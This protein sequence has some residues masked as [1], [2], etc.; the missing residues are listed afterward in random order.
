MEIIKV[1]MALIKSVI[2]KTKLDKPLTLTETDSQRLFDLSKAHDMAHLVAFSIDFNEVKVPSNVKANFQKEQ[3][4]AVF[5][6]E[7]SNYEIQALYNLFEENNIEYVPLKGA[8]L[9]AFYPEPYLRTSADIDILVHEEQIEKSIKL[10]CEK[11][12]YKQKVYGPHDISLI[13]PSGVNF[14]L[15][16]DLLDNEI[17][18]KTPKPLEDMWN[19]TV[20]NDNGSLRKD[21]VDELFYYYHIAH[22]A[23]H[24]LYGGCGIK[25]FIDLWV[26]NNLVKFD[27]EKRLSWL[28]D[29]GLEE[30][31]KQVNLLCKIWFEGATHTDM[32]KQMESYILKGGV[33]GT[34]EN[35]V[36][37]G[38]IKRGNKFKYFFARIW[39]PYERLKYRYPKLEKRKW[40]LP[41]YQV[42]R[43]FGIVFN[44]R[45]KKS[46]NE[47]KILNATT[48]DDKQKTNQML[49]DLEIV[50]E[51]TIK[52]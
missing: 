25:P 37:V 45:F 11:L 40:L 26:L 24:F 42:K 35:N 3:N 43:W 20:V 2:T 49:K 4:I 7:K 9:S 17:T 12:N 13:S 33:Y 30:F 32:T 36:A 52:Y 19:H 48:K 23:K 28:K 51:N 1:L 14:E 22:M 29:G 10:I 50:N 46:V 38:Q 6:Y 15:H 39:I 31:D 8:V 5:R 34:I 44:D 41:F 18:I 47:M 16:Y 27:R 21:F